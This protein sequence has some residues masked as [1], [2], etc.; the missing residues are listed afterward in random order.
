VPDP[1]AYAYLLG[2]Y[3]GDGHLTH[4]A[5]GTWTLR[6][7]CDRAYPSIEDEIATA[8]ERTFPGARARRWARRGAAADILCVCHP[9]LGRAFP[10]HG[11]DRKH[12]R[13]IWLDTWQR[14]ITRLHPG[15]LIRGLI[16]SDGCRSINRFRT[17]LP[18]GR[19]AQ[20]SYV[21]YFFSNRSE[22]IRQI[23]I[24]HCCLLGIRVTQSNPRNLSV[25][26]RTSVALLEELVGP[27][28]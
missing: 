9:A 5:P 16:H 12:L 22:D 8:M 6:V 15:M 24:D 28:Q 25:S 13:P 17:S 3:L 23:F 20:Y 21:R 7:A 26:D 10:Q 18:G 14:D 19:V 2:C 11:P 27:K 1:R 4:K